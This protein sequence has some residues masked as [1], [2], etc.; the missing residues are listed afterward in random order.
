MAT[1]LRAA[2]AA[3]PDDS[4]TV[5][6]EVEYVPAAGMY[7][8]EVEPARDGAAAVSLAFDGCWGR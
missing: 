6:C 8:T 7:F 5:T 1:L 2:L 3:C 4:G